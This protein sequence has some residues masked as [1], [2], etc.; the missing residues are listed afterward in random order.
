[1]DLPLETD[2]TVFGD[3]DP[4]VETGS[5]HNR[6]FRVEGDDTGHFATESSKR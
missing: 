1:M 5:G 2:N 6:A 4:A 3:D